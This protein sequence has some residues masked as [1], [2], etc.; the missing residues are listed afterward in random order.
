MSSENL[1]IETDGDLLLIFTRRVQKKDATAVNA[2]LGKRKSPHDTSDTVTMLVSSKHMASASSVF[3]V[4]IEEKMQRASKTSTKA[5]IELLLPR[6]DPT[7]FVIVANI[8]HGRNKTVPEKVEYQLLVSLGLITERY[9]L[10]ECLRFAAISWINNL[11]PKG[12]GN[13]PNW[14]PGCNKEA[15][16]INFL[17]WMFGMRDTFMLYTKIAILHS[18]EN[19][20]FPVPSAPRH[21]PAIIAAIQKARLQVFSDLFAALRS[22][23]MRGTEAISYCQTTPKDTCD[24][25]TAGSFMKSCARHVAWPLPN[26]PYKG[27]RVKTVIE[28]ILETGIQSR[29][30]ESNPDSKNCINDQMFEKMIEVQIKVIESR[31]SGL[32]MIFFLRMRLSL[33]SLTVRMSRL[34]MR[35]VRQTLERG[36]DPE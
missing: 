21:L 1:I 27:L 17:V 6:E 2:V 36:P 30:K 16:Y 29:C 25:M 11:H 4:M 18:D 9:K 5:K 26:L 20:E 15:V 14:V 8:I 28:N 31:I 33:L 3:K 10:E 12:L 32:D 24:F 23:H 7:P 34:A 13:F 35:R 19:F 22:F